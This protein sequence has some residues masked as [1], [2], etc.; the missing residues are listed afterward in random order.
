MIHSSNLPL[1]KRMLFP[2]SLF[3]AMAWG[4]TAVMLSIS[5]PCRGAEA[6]TPGFM[7]KFRGGSL[8]SLQNKSVVYL[9]DNDQSLPGAGVETILGDFQTDSSSTTELD[10][11]NPQ[12]LELLLPVTGKSGKTMIRETCAI[13]ADSGDLIVTQHADSDTAGLKEVKWSLGMIPLE[14]NIIVPSGGGIRLTRESPEDTYSFV[15]AMGWEAQLVIIES[16]GGGFYIWAE[17]KA[18]LFKQLQVRRTPKGWWLTFSSINSAP[19][20]DKK[21]A[22]SAKWRLNTYQGDWRVPARRYRDWAS[23]A[24]HPELLKKNAPDWVKEIRT[25]I[26]PGRDA[27]KLPVIASHVDPRQTLLYVYDWRKADYDRNYPDYEAS[28]WVKG[29]IEKAHALGFRVMLYTNFWGLDLKH[30]LYKEFEACQVRT[31]PSPQDSMVYRNTRQNPPIVFAYINP[32]SKKWRAEFISRIKKVVA[33]LNPDGIHLDQNF[34]SHNDFNGLID[35]LTMNEGV[36]AMHREIRQA[37]PDIALGAEGLNELTA[38][39]VSFA[40]RHV[41]SAIKG[42]ID[43]GALSTAHPISSYLFLPYVK[44]YG[45][46]GFAAPEE[47]PQVYNAWRENWRIWGVLPT[48]KFIRTTPAMLAQPTAFLRQNLDEIHFWQ[49]ERVEP[50]LDG[51]W[52]A[53][54]LFPYKTSSGQSVIVTKDRTVLSGNLEISRTISDVNEVALNGR[55]DDW[56]LYD[57]KRLFGLDPRK[58]YAYF[59]SERDS[60]AFHIS[61]LPPGFSVTEVQCSADQF[62]ASITQNGGLIYHFAD[63]LSQS[64]TGI[65]LTNGKEE[66]KKGSFSKMRGATVAGASGNIRMVPPSKGVLTTDFESDKVPQSTGL[67]ST[68]ARFKTTLPSGKRLRFT[69]E[70]GI[71]GRSI[72][73]GM[74]DGVIFHFN[75]NAGK[76]SLTRQL[77][78]VQS[79]P[80]SWEIDLSSYAGQE[81]EIELGVDPGPANNATEDRAIWFYPRIEED[82]SS[83]SGQLVLANTPVWLPLAAKEQNISTESKPDGLILR[84]PMPGR[85]ELHAPKNKSPDATAN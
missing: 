34:H 79:K 42:T 62:M 81:V 44:L 2:R 12:S 11:K 25:V 21:T 85:I 43:R 57:N 38:Q 74:T 40:Q 76:N 84:V 50:D 24:F 65:K 83:E 8:V 61:S 49:K 47:N 46:P 51:E 16:A 18:S 39:S 68:Y 7:A 26:L 37:L 54:V 75:M 14:S 23:N 10:S 56:K 82:L 3:H 53:Q 73:K 72:G 60:H 33:E 67:G 77:S 41:Y 1:Q 31:G 48:A 9:N 15:Y 80:V 35:G 66:E 32:A 64:A 19:F 58:W 6:A 45:W 29:F 27:G 69:S 20:D 17:D 4:L 52:P 55:I 22:A 71:D 5:L 36:L 78:C 59:A 63:H 70:V 13:D 30:P 28:P